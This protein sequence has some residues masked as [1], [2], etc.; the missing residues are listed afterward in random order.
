MRYSDQLLFCPRCDG[1]VPLEHGTVTATCP[2][3]RMLVSVPRRSPA[4]LARALPLA[5]SPVAPHGRWLM[6]DG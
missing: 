3:C 6:A 1:W 2:Y 4:V 5:P